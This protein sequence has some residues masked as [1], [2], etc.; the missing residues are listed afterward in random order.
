MRLK[1]IKLAG[2]KSFVDP[3]HVHLTS[4]LTAV[5]GPNGCGKSNIIDAVR[6]VMG[7][8]SAKHL[9]GESMADVIFNGS[10]S[11]KPVSRAAI[12][13]VFEN[14]EGRAPGEFAK[15][16]EI[17]VKR[18]V[19]R[20]G[21]SKYFLNGTVCRRRDVTDLF[22]GTGL[23]P[24]SYAIIEQGMIARLIEAK[25]DDLR[26]YVE[27]AA[28][29]SKY[30]E[31]RRETES[32]IT[33]TRENL[34]R[35]TDLSD[36]L[37][38][39]LDRLKRQAE[40]A[41]RYQALKR[42]AR[43]AEAAILWMQI[44]SHQAQQQDL[45][46]QLAEYAHSLTM[47]ETERIQNERQRIEAQVARA[48][49]ADALDQANT[50]FYTQS[51]T[52]SRMEAQLA[53]YDRALTDRRQRL[54]GMEDERVRLEQQI[55]SDR[56]AMTE[57]ETRAASLVT[58]LAESEAARNRIQPVLREQLSRRD[59]LQRAQQSMQAEQ[60]RLRQEAH[61][62]MTQCETLERQQAKDQHRLSQIE[63]ALTNLADT[64]P[65]VITDA[66][67]SH[68]Q[69]KQVLA[70]REEAAR[71]GQHIVTEARGNCEAARALARTAQGDVEAAEL[72]LQRIER[73]LIAEF[74]GSEEM[75]AWAQS[76]P[77]VSRQVIEVIAIPT[78]Q[79]E[80]FES[81][82]GDWLSAWIVSELTADLVD[83]LP[84][85]V[86]VVTEAQVARLAA[87]PPYLAS[88]DPA[89]LDGYSDEGLLFGH[90]W[91]RRAQP[92]AQGMLALQAAKPDARQ[93][94]ER[95][96]ETQE[97]A[98][99]ALEIA[100]HAV[101]QAEQALQRREQDVQEARA[102]EAQCNH[103]CIGLLAKA[104]E[105]AD[106]RA[107]LTDERAA[108]LEDLKAL[109]GQLRQVQTHQK[110]LDLQR[111]RLGSDLSP[112][113]AELTSVLEGLQELYRQRDA[114][115]RDRAQLDLRQERTRTELEAL[116]RQLARSSEQVTAST[117]RHEA[118]QDELAALEQ[119][120]PMTRETLRQPVQESTRLE[121]V[122]TE[123]RRVVEGYDETLR[124]LDRSR[125]QLEQQ[126]GTVRESQ[127]RAQMAKQALVIECQQWQGQLAPLL[128][129]HGLAQ[130]TAYTEA[131]ETQQS[132]QT[133]LTQIT[134]R[135][136][137]LGP[138]NL[139][140]VDEY[141]RELE[142]KAELDTQSA[143]L[144]EALETLEE[145][146]RKI[147]RETRQLF[148]QTFDAM[149]QSFGALFPTLFGGGEAWLEL[150]DTDLLTTGVTI[151]ARPPGKRN[152]TIYL[153]SGGEKALTALALVFAIFQLN[154]A[155]FCLLDEVDAPLDDANVGRYAEAVA[156][157][158]QR[159]QFIYITHNKL[160]MERA[161][162]LMGVTMSEP[163]VSRLVS[164]DIERAVE[165]ATTE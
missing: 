151:M 56:Q 28:G 165:L 59:A 73:Q 66:Q 109:E 92:A 30:K 63:H 139:V 100:E 33:R 147:D 110:T 60:Q 38:R 58:E 95:A 10:V 72:A 55:A 27:E 155:P 3:T 79:R 62:M 11:R 161:E 46:R 78:A 52:I 43:L 116:A 6:W 108:L 106:L 127:Q 12:E 41:K 126:R 105:V 82:L 94:L 101:V 125:D 162:C 36:E 91:C 45:E 83:L 32:R 140:A 51:A 111:D 89:A 159:V 129:E 87:N 90:G 16:A 75:H 152:S 148:R 115:D 48:S 39:Q 37:G 53:E 121:R 141:Q 163:G 134:Q 118:L 24:R 86:T 84:M 157:M 34:A 112:V 114:V 143:E 47:A 18:E 64:D 124:T 4:N 67:S 1:S 145:A 14:H 130:V 137:R 158:S 35:L 98:L 136:E 31:R 50:Q 65:Q 154:P 49:A 146:I 144:I 20:D 160:A 149:N 26:A 22:L 29:V 8:S 77:E 17:S 13:L 81:A 61:A 85:G 5:V 15:Y 96:R 164:V 93:A 19:T 122:L 107:R 71:D 74:N 135:I 40:A 68:V 119:N 21:Q 2:F 57:A 153:L 23:G 88:Y 150:T 69:A 104:Q 113:E 133:E 102:H 103:R 138:I 156:A 25:P 7:E 120:P 76:R 44:Q 42:E 128:E 70:T 132:V 123:A 97:T 54:A 131:R 80:A 9:R 117:A 142:R 99:R